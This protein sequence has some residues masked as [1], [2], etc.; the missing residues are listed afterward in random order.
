MYSN[1]VA[2]INRDY[3]RI[4]T[5]IFIIFIKNNPPTVEVHKILDFSCFFKFCSGKASARGGSA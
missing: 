1:T 2:Q 3:K 4:T 5:N